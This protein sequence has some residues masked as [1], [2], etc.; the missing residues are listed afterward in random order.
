MG[1]R[2]FCFGHLPLARSVPCLSVPFIG[3]IA[4]INLQNLGE[5][6][7]DDVEIS[8]SVIGVR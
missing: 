6:I 2:W 5:S 3:V 1:F 8:G 7:Y 4:T